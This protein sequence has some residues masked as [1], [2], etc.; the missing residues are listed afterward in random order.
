IDEA[1]VW[2]VARSASDLAADRFRI[3]DNAPDGL[4]AFWRFEEAG[5]VANDHGPNNIAGAIGP[6]VARTS[7]APLGGVRFRGSEDTDLVITLPGEDPEGGT[8]AARIETLP[9]N[10]ALFQWQEGAA[11]API[12]AGQTVL[13]ARRR[14]IYRPSTN[15]FGA[16]L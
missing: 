11:G 14:V 4:V 12:A 16:A 13:D 5:S 15:A 2:A 9:A 1:R 8:C 3:L 10:G 7:G 6:G